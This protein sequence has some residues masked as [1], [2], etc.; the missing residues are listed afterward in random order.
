MRLLILLGSLGLLAA[1]LE[2]IL[3]PGWAQVI[4]VVTATA[5]Y[6]LAAHWE[7]QARIWRRSATAFLR[8]SDELCQGRD[9]DA[10]APP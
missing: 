9:G 10:G 7:E 6:Q 1:M 8:I 2:G 4:L 3:L 5:S